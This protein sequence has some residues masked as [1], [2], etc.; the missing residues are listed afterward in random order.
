[1]DRKD[2]THF[3]SLAIIWWNFEMVPSGFG[4]FTVRSKKSVSIEVETLEGK[5]VQ[6]F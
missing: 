6:D 3:I 5:I 1:M 2:T 4:S